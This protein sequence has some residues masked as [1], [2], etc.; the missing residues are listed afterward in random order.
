MTIDPTD[1][2]RDVSVWEA[3][4]ERHAGSPFLASEV[5]YSLSEPIIDAIKTL[6]PDFFTKK[7]V[8]FERDL[9]RTASFGFQ[10]RRALGYRKSGAGSRADLQERLA[11]VAAEIR[12]MLREELQG[13]GVP[14]TDIGS[15]F[16][17][18]DNERD[19]I[20]TRQSAYVGWLVTN[21]LFRA[22]VKALREKWAPRVRE[23]TYFPVYP[24]YPLY[25]LGYDCE[26]PDDFRDEFLSL[27]RRWGIRQLLTWDWPVPMEP[28]LASGLLSDLHLLAHS[29]VVLF[30]PWY[31]V[32]GEKMN[33]QDIVRRIRTAQV[34]PHLREWVIGTPYSKDDVGEIRYARTA[35][36][37]RFLILALQQRYP[38]ARRG[39]IH[40]LDEA[41]SGLLDRDAESVRKLR[42]G[43][44]RALR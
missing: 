38:T 6:V 2:E 32:R 7:E 1:P 34:P 24:H 27:Y 41:F 17:N 44:A 20:V 26:V 3:F 28:D 21:S 39:K 22:E 10:F 4:A 36:L 43:L 8:E 13:K 14:E 16:H 25:D 33:L 31:L 11:Q 5:I 15:S 23:L 37:F 19:A 9:A 12:S 29:G 35:W 42:Q 30:A 18:A 40:Q